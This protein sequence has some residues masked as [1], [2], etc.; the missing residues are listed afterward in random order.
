MDT[1]NQN[2]AALLAESLEK[3]RQLRRQLEAFEEE[4]N[5]PI[6]IIGIGCRFPGGI[7]DE[8]GYWKV[9]SQG[10]DCIGEIPPERW[11]IEEYYDPDPD[12][13]GKMYA[14]HGGFLEGVD[15]FEPQIFGISPLEAS[16]MDPQQRL[17][18]EVTYGAL[19]LSLIHI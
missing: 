10:V 4:A 13:P 8:D 17:L 14:R 11:S 18:L 15:L 19:E 16:S 1:K 6:A 9:L 3:I 5:E 7:E 2:Y 12:K